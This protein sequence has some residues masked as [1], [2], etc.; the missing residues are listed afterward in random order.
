MVFVLKLVCRVPGDSVTDR[1]RSHLGPCNQV[2]HRQA[3]GRRALAPAQLIRERAPGA[4][5]HARCGAARCVHLSAEKA[6]EDADSSLLPGGY[7]VTIHVVSPRLCLPRYHSGTQRCFP[8]S[9]RKASSSLPIG[10]GTWVRR[11]RMQLGFDQTVVR[12]PC[13]RHGAVSCVLAGQHSRCKASKADC[14]SGP[15]GIFSAP[16]RWGQLPVLPAA[17]RPSPGNLWS[18]KNIRT[19]CTD[20]A[21]SPPWLLSAPPAPPFSPASLQDPQG[22]ARTRP[23][24][25][26]ATGTSRSRRQQLVAGSLGAGQRRRGPAQ[27]QRRAGLPVAV[28]PAGSAPARPHPDAQGPLVPTCLPDAGQT[29]CWASGTGHLSFCPSPRCLAITGFPSRG[30]WEEGQSAFGGGG[31]GVGLWPRGSP[32]SVFT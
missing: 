9:C 12:G 25:C 18:C 10:G 15:R 20:L 4:C 31:W 26:R 16:G 23:P 32:S 27:V 22:K 3:G 17:G 5:A 29:R 24:V 1:P 6:E 2:C 7:V 8:L 21:P 28:G 13:R 30:T 11:A 14:G 19:I